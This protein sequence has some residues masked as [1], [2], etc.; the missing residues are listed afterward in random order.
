MILLK[1]KKA[2]LGTMILLAGSVF[3][4]AQF[5]QQIR[6]TVTD[7][8]LQKPVAGATVYLLPVNKSV[9]TDSLGNFRFMNVPV[10]NKQILA[11]HI[12]FKQASIENIVVNAG[13][14]VV[15]SITMESLVRSENAVVIKT[16]S[17]KK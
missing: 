13:K 10:G 15:L 9:I 3:S 2:G 8:V 5:T 14:E 16:A 11:S 1:K 7:Q 12:G 17:K 6:G 4:N